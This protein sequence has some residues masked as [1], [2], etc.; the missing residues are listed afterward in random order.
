MSPEN[1]STSED[2]YSSSKIPS[3]AGDITD[4]TPVDDVMKIPMTP[5][6]PIYFSTVF[7][8]ISN[9]NTFVTAYKTTYVNT[10]P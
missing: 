6:T 3:K 8:L 2:E 9:R 4:N 10:N 7:R 5:Y 1:T